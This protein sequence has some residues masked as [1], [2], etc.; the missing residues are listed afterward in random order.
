MTFRM[1]CHTIYQTAAI[2]C[3]PVPLSKVL[4]EKTVIKYYEEGNW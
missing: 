4:Y 3:N 1:I 2:L